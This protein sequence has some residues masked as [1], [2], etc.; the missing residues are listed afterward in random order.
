M[1]ANVI[2]VKLENKERYDHL[3]EAHS[4]ENLFGGIDF[5]G[6]FNGYPPDYPCLVEFYIGDHDPFG[7]MYSN[8]L[9]KL[10]N[11]GYLIQVYKDEAG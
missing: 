11:D 5:K 6:L 2:G 10:M 1:A 7:F 8:Q 3:M 4:V 9:T